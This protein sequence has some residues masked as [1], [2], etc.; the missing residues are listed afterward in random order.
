[1]PEFA[2]EL[3][4]FVNSGGKAVGATLRVGEQGGSITVLTFGAR[5]SDGQMGVTGDVVPDGD[6]QKVYQWQFEL[7]HAIVAGRLH[8][9]PTSH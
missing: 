5:F 7:L 6:L 3:E 9:H 8:E 4:A 2:E 1:M